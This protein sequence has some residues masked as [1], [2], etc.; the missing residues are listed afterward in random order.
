MSISDASGAKRRWL[1]SQLLGRS[2]EE[3]LR[4]PRVRKALAAEAGAEALLSGEILARLRAFLSSRTRRIETGTG[5][6]GDRPLDL[7]AGLKDTIDPS[8][9]SI[10]VRH[11]RRPRRAN[12]ARA[13]IE[14][15][16]PRE[17]NG[18]FLPIHDDDQATVDDLAR[19]RQRTRQRAR[20]E[21]VIFQAERPLEF[22][23][24]RGRPELILDESNLLPF[25]FLRTGDRLGRAVVKIERGDG[26]AG[27]AFLVAPGV[28][29]TNHHVLPDVA[30]A[31]GARA[32][33]NFEAAPPAG[34]EGRAAVVPLDP[35]GLFVTNEELDFT[36]CGVEGLDFLGVVP[37]SRDSLGIAEGECVNIIQHPRGRPKEVALRDNQV[38]KLDHVVVR[39]CCDTEPGS[40]G[41]PVF[42]NQ[43]MLVAL[44][45]A[46]VVANEPKA[47]ASAS[48]P[49]RY[50]NEGVRLSAIALWLEAAGSNDAEDAESLARL[51]AIFRGLDPRIGY[52]GALGSRTVGRTAAE[53]IVES[54]RGE[55]DHLDLGFWDLRALARGSFDRLTDLGW[56]LADMRLDLWC[57]VGLTADLARALCEHLETNFQLDYAAL[58]PDPAD[59]LAPTI[60]YRRSRALTV[61]RL[62]WG[63]DGPVDLDALSS[64]RV[65][66]APKGGEPTL[67]HL[68][69]LVPQG[70]EEGIASLA[71]AISLRADEATDWVLIGPGARLDPE[72]TAE[73]VKVGVG[74]LAATDG[75]DGAVTVLNGSKSRVGRIFVSPNQ[76]RTDSTLNGLV[77]NDDR[78]FPISIQGLGHRRPIALRLSFGA[79]RPVCPEGSVPPPS[80]DSPTPSPR[81]ERPFLDDPETERALREWLAPLVAQ[82]I[83][84]MRQER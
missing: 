44:H 46:S 28:L 19:L 18:A 31:A 84:E 82:M 62:D 75:E 41:S 70:N 83:A 80:V 9:Q 13:E 14:P 48:L 40:S 10:P 5:A 2:F 26:A 24:V 65:R 74:S 34:P 37:P 38:V 6:Q 33:A 30:T 56:V 71:R 27:T 72:T 1:L 55:G 58:P 20:R 61:S 49:G 79:A 81:R 47:R 42:N 68:T 73:L 25:G 66:I 21:A 17:L 50:L 69:P 16:A 76:T 45:H 54:Y 78:G 64:L 7:P 35:D 63:E 22:D 36:F 15:Q 39:Y 23:A 60:L 11:R 77:F 43:W 8:D 32:R 52:F 51:R 59:R 57:L 53:V 67:I 12:A 4:L 3:V 29:L